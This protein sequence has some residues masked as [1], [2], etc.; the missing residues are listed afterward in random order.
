MRKKSLAK[1]IS[2]VLCCI[3]VAFSVFSV[4]AIDD[5]YTIDELGM[6]LKIP[7]EYTVVTRTLDKNDEAFSKLSLDYDDTMNAFYLDHIYLQAV[8][9]DGKL[10]INLTSVTDEN[11]KAI[12]NYSDLSEA[13]RL[14]ALNTFLKDSSYI[15]GVEIKHND[16]I[17]F[18][19]ELSSQGANDVIFAY[20]CHTVVNGMNINLTMQKAKESFTA[21]EIKIITNIADSIDFD[22]IHL[23]TGL[24][25]DWWRLLLWIL[26]LVLVSIFASYIYRRYAKNH[27]NIKER[28]SKQ[29][30][31]A[32]IVAQDGEADKG[33]IKQR[34]IR[35]SKA[36]L[37]SQLG[38]V[39]D[40][41]K[42][43][44]PVTFDEMLGYDTTDYRTRANT[45]LESF[46][47]K[48]K[49]S[50]RN[51]GV[52]YF[53]DDGEGIN[54]KGDYFD[55]FFRGEIERNSETSRTASGI[56]VYIKL[57]FRH[58]GYFFINLWRMIF[59]SKK[60]KHKSRKK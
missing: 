29:R 3:I 24:A 21:D 30:I 27:R 41:E 46:D 25:F 54:K 48:V 36:E 32:K 37:L 15:S 33:Q 43:E 40:D 19:F 22:E 59:P 56:F 38:F 52:S 57:G 13:Q 12:N 35:E 45:D 23:K 49:S 1:I 7:K 6:S 51:R 5:T 11:S 16:S 10:K 8:S 55:E 31:S 20:Q 34:P 50:N 60:T 18:D 26:I 2:L 28:K 42:E 39:D 14:E 44:K 58:L 4:G 9:E 17:Y 47:I 53:E